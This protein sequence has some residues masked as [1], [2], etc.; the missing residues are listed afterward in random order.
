MK[1]HA[2]EY[3]QH[4]NSTTATYT[5]C[6]ICEASSFLQVTKMKWSVF[7]REVTRNFGF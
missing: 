6:L 4:I 1:Y 7:R 2:L 3:S 5:E